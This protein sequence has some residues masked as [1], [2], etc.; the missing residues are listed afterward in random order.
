MKNV[1][2]VQYKVNSILLLIL[3]VRK[4]EN[5]P[6]IHRLEFKALHHKAKHFFSW[7]V[8]EAIELHK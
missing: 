5:K 7:L 4:K 8:A 2:K 3:C 1:L 6:L